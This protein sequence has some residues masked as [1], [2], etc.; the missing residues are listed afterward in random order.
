MSLLVERSLRGGLL[1]EAN[2]EAGDEYTCMNGRR[3]KF[4]SVRCCQDL[5]S[6]IADA[7]RLRDFSGMRTDSRAHLNGYLGVLRRML[8]KSNRICGRV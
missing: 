5:E 6:R 7:C 3:V 2:Y 4:G 8:R 1:T